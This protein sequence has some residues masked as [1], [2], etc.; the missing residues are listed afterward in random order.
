MRSAS[1]GRFCGRWASA[2]V[3]RAGTSR[4]TDGKSTGRAI[5]DGST[6]IAMRNARTERRSWDP[7]QGT[8]GLV[9]LH[10]FSQTTQAPNMGAV[11]R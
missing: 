10:A 2:V 7:K 1:P 11:P 9:V 6:V 4:M 5:G 3:S 8:S